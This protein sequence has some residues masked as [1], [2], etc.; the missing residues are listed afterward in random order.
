MERKGGPRGILLLLR[1]VVNVIGKAER[2][3]KWLW[4]PLFWPWLWL[5]GILNPQC[6][7]PVY[8]A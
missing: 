3:G 1:S 7:S 2:K 4:G 6:F 8:E 5:K